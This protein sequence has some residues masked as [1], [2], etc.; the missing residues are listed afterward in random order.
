[1]ILRRSALYQWHFQFHGQRYHQNIHDSG[2][3]KSLEKAIPLRVTRKRNP[4][5]ESLEEDSEVSEAHSNFKHIRT[6]KS[7]SLFTSLGIFAFLLILNRLKVHNLIPYI[8]FGIAMWYFMLHSGVHATISGV[9]LAFAI[10]FGD[11]SE[12][13]PSYNFTTSTPSAGGV[14]NPAVIRTCKHQHLIN[15]ALVPGAYHNQWNRNHPRLGCRKACG[16]FDIQFRFRHCLQSC[17][18]P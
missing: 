8:V 12:K 10:P 4:P 13:S 9:L 3:S 17:V 1:M 18:D 6:S 7:T 15:I 11:G 5:S 14:Y 16:Y 2:S